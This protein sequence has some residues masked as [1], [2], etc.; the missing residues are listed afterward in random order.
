MVTGE[1]ASLR[2]ES[3]LIQTGRYT[4]ENGEKESHMGTE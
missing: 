4:K 1:M 3:A 2:M